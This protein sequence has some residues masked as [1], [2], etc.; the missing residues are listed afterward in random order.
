MRRHKSLQ[1]FVLAAVLLVGGYAISRSFASSDDVL[2]PGDRPP[3]FRLSG[4]D[5][6]EHALEDYRGRPLVLNFWGTFCPPCREEMPALQR[7]YEKWKDRGLQV[8]GINLSEDRLRVQNFIRQA[9]VRFPILLDVDRRTERAF[10]LREY[11]T[12]YFIDSEGV[13][14][15]IVVGGPLTEEAIAE[16]VEPLLAAHA[17]QGG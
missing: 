11:P 10:G 1:Y 15:D 4:L 17:R 9:G 2:R 8:V 5:G 3:S 16:R 6:R 14:R 13:I 7:Q 12:T